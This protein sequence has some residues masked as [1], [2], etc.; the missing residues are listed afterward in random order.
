MP[1]HSSICPAS[2]VVV[3]PTSHEQNGEAMRLL[4]SGVASRCQACKQKWN[5]IMKAPRAPKPSKSPKPQKSPKSPK[6]PKS[7]KAVY[8]GAGVAVL[9]LVCFCIARYKK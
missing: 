8:A 3:D 6:P 2:S 4:K 1:K 5:E 7:Y 9:L